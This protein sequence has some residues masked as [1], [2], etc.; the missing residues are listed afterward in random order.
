MLLC[1]GTVVDLLNISFRFQCYVGIFKGK[2][3]CIGY[4]GAFRAFGTIY[5]VDIFG[6]PMFVK[7]KES[8]F[9]RSIGYALSKYHAPVH[10]TTFYFKFL[11][12]IVAACD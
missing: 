4:E 3:A 11:E 9:Q 10:G 6:R 8:L 2:N 12:H 7:S 5:M 1:C